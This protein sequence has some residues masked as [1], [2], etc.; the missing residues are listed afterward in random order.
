MDYELIIVG[1]GPAGLSAAL[2]SSYRKMKAL[3]LESGTAG[4]ALTNKYPWKHVDEVLGQ[5]EMVGYQIAGKMVEHVR[6]EGA[7]VRENESVEKITKQNKEFTIESNKGKYTCKS[8]ILAIGLGVPR[9]LGVP[10]ENLNGVVYS[11]S[12]P[13]DYS[14]RN[15]VVVGGGDSAVESAVMLSQ[16]NAE[17]T[18]VHR[19]EECRASEKNLKDLSESKVKLMLNTELVEVVGSG[20]V[21]KVVLVSNKD[22][23]R[24]ELNADAVLLSLGTVSNKAFLESIGIKTDDKGNVVVD[25][26]QRTNIE[27]VFAAGDVTGRW[28][29]IPNAIAEGGY[30]AIN[31]YKYVKK[32]YW[33]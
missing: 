21:E 31:A 17:T 20:R 32:P 16:N 28:V 27:G 2:S 25:S 11:L 23:Q 24:K 14:K 33:A 3:V 8:V 4:G 26:Q 15:V 7:E 29:R 22:K 12:N 5:H 13:A 30:A 1:G 6:K 9:K 19:G 10:G 18:L